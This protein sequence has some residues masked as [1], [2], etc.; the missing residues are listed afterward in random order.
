MDQPIPEISEED[1]VSIVVRDFGGE[2]LTK[3]V[4]ILE[5]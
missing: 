3:V 4:S 2:K 5:E 1:V